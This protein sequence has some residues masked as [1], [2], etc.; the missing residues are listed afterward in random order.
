M[1]SYA[2]KFG[3]ATFIG[4][5]LCL[6]GIALFPTF[7]KIIH[8]SVSKELVLEKSSYI[9]DTW[10]HPT[11][12]VHM[13]FWFWDLRN[14]HEVLNGEQPI[15]VQKGPYTYREHLEKVDIKWNGNDTVSFRQIYSY[16]FQPNMS[17]GP[18]SDVITTMNIPLVTIVNMLK[19]QIGPIQDIADI[20]VEILGDA[21]LF[22]PLS[23]KDIVW[24]YRDPI[25][26][27][28]Y[29]LTGTSIVPSPDFGLFLGKNNSDD[30]EYT[31]FTGKK[32][33][34]KL[35]IIDRWNGDMNLHW[36]SDIYANMINGTDASLNPPFTSPHDLHYVFPSIACRSLPG[37]FLE[38]T[39]VRGI[40]VDRFAG[41]SYVFDNATDYPPNSG[42]CIPDVNHCLPS[43]FLDVS[44][45]QQGAPIVLSLPHYL[46]VKDQSH[47][48]PF[49]NPS[50]EEHQTYVEAHRLTGVTLRAAKR[51]Q[52]NVH[53]Q[54]NPHYEEFVKVREVFYPI[55][56]LNESYMMGESNAEE[57]KTKVVLPVTVTFIVQWAVLA[58]G[59]F[60]LIVAF[61]TLLHRIRRGRMKNYGKM[62]DDAPS[63]NDSGEESEPD[64]QNEEHNDELN[65]SEERDEEQTDG[66]IN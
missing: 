56:W 39:S 46:F 16:V 2:V 57:F 58:L 55:L 52:I 20:L 35:N 26:N 12:P 22:K 11:D 38:T 27:L 60:I 32:D 41:P 54:S 24:G 6:L 65:R 51:M 34:N 25:F 59:L 47:V 62:N 31:V 64:S 1:V 43:G 13:Q 45:C 3:I 5:L 7:T 42:F 23:V 50:M 36:W 28:I 17:S 37:E 40:A 44:K 63:D 49:M 53:L 18:E 15:V 66:K 9:Y 61:I 19:S 14:Q 30:G 29:N 33:I 21:K 8:D 4:I 48:L 10:Q